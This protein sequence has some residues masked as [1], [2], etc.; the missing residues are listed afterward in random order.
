LWSTLTQRPARR[1]AAITGVRLARSE[2]QRLLDQHVDAGASSSIAS[3]ACVAGGV[4]T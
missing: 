1:A 3:G 2:R 4:S